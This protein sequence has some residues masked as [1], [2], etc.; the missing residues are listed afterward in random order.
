[1]LALVG[2]LESTFQTTAVTTEGAMILSIHLE[3][4]TVD[5]LCQAGLRTKISRQWSLNRAGSLGPAPVHEMTCANI[6]YYCLHVM[7]DGGRKS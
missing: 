7:V 1:M 4:L 3:L 5:R 6:A 2:G